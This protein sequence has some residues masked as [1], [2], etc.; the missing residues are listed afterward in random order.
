MSRADRTEVALPRLSLSLAD[1]VPATVEARPIPVKPTSPQAAKSPQASESLP[2]LEPLRKVYLIIDGLNVGRS[3]GFSDPE[4]LVREHV[5]KRVRE[6]VHGKMCSS[7]KIATMLEHIDA[8]NKRDD[9]S[10]TAM[11]ILPE[12]HVFGGRCA[13]LFA[14]QYEKLLA[15]EIRSR[16]VLT[17][18]GIDDDLFGLKLLREK[19]ATGE[20]Y[21]ISNDTFKDHNADDILK[22]RHV[23]FAWAGG[24]ELIVC[25]PDGVDLP[26]L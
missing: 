15:T 10:Y 21:I 24:S 4:D 16:L 19:A 11:C 17:P 13:N 12:H 7:N 6:G 1:F 3:E 8:A 5:T 9:V 14:L 20:A 23:R 25:A 2:S 18:A 26:G 22:G